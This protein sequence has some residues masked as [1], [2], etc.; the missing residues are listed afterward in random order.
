MIL[1]EVVREFLDEEGNV[2]DFVVIDGFNTREEAFNF[3]I[4]QNVNDSSSQI[5]IYESE[6]DG[7]VV[8]SDVVK[9]CYC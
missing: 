8:D 6:D 5:T 2:N 9:T 7:S 4:A 1:Y 3:A